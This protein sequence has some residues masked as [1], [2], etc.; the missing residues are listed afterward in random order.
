MLTIPSIAAAPSNAQRERWVGATKAERMKAA[1]SSGAANI[2]RTARNSAMT[3]RGSWSGQEEANAITEAA[4]M[5]VTA[6]ANDIIEMAVQN[7]RKSR[8]K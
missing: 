4:A 6:S 7:G 3:H 5:P 8:R 1:A 2:S